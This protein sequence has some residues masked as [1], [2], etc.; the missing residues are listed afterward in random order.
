[1]SATYNVTINFLLVI[2]RLH[3]LV[4]KLDTAEQLTEIVELAQILFPKTYS[5][6]S[7]H[8]HINKRLETIG[9]E[10]DQ[11]ARAYGLVYN[12]YLDKEEQIFNAQRST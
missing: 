5:L 4:D 11:A 9:R 8:N 1:M 12:P 6:N 3:F 7:F 10:R 2:N